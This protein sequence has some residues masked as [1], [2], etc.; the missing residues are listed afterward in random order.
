MKDFNIIKGFRNINDIDR[1]RV[2]IDDFLLDVDLYANFL[3]ENNLKGLVLYS[4]NENK[5]VLDLSFLER[6]SFLEY[7]ECLVPL[8][9]KSNADGLYLLPELKYLR[10]VVSNKFS[11]DYSHL[12]SLE[13]LITSDYGDMVNWDSLSNLRKLH[14]TNLKK[15]NCSFVS[16]LMKITDLKLARADITSIR[17]LENCESLMRLELERCN[18]IVELS[19]VI[20]KCFVLN[21][22]SLI[23]CKNI[24]SEQFD[25]IKELGISLWIE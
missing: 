7:F 17:G 25:K 15:D 18:K 13:V 24:K 12:T 2:N 5:H 23:K 6:F 4:N 21:S 20:E 16:R 22:V 1:L 10:W 14:I 19:S 11:L 8:S 9:K 3:K